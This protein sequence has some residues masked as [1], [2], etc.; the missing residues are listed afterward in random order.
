MKAIREGE[1]PSPSRY[2]GGGQWLLGW[3]DVLPGVSGY[4]TDQVIDRSKAP[5]EQCLAKKLSQN[6]DV[7]FPKSCK[8]RKGNHEQG[9]QSVRD[10]LANAGQVVGAGRASDSGERPAQSARAQTGGTSV[11]A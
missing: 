8:S 7:G 3:A 6:R 1:P 11:G 2:A 4:R 5:L 9:K 10:P